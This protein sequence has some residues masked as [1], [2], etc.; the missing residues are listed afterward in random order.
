MAAGRKRTVLHRPRQQVDGG[1]A[2]RGVCLP[3]GCSEGPLS[4]PAGRVGALAVRHAFLV[5]GAT[6]PGSG[7]LH[8]CPQLAGGAEEMKSTASGIIDPTARPRLLVTV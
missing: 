3:G 4:G 8:D 7:T 2:L 5:P 1:Y 6:D